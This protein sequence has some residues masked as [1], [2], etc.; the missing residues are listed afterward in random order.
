MDIRV[1]KCGEASG[2]ILVVF[3]EDIC[4]CRKYVILSLIA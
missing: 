1:S 3:P 2:S 4:W